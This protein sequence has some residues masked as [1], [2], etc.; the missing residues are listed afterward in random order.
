MEEVVKFLN[1]FIK[2]EH[3]TNLLSRK[4]DILLYNKAL[5]TMDEFLR[6]SLKQGLGMMKMDEPKYASFYEF[7]DLVPVTKERYFFRLNKIST[8]SNFLYCAYMSSIDGPR[9]YFNTFIVKPKLN[10]FEIVSVFTWGKGKTSKNHWYYSVGEEMRYTDLKPI[11][12]S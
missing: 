3:N 10:S 11:Q 4:P 1:T 8:D 12:I 6:I 5:D 7:A 9:K 2:A